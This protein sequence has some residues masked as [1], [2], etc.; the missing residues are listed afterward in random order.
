MTTFTKSDVEQTGLTW[1]EALGYAIASVPEIA[2]GDV[3]AKRG[4]YD[5]VL[6]HRRT[7][8]G[9]VSHLSG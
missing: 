8:S 1:P 7:S 3:D 4:D 2:P 6:L 5:Q 9:F